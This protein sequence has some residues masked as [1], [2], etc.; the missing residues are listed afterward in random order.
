MPC[1][2]DEP[3]PQEQR[4]AYEQAFLHNST[5]ADIF[6]K[7]MQK[8]DELPAIATVNDLRQELPT[9]ALSWWKEHKLRDQ[10]RLNAELSTARRKNERQ[11]AIDKLTPY[12]RKLLGLDK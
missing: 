6:C 1:R 8:I 12:E 2:T 11:A 4:A 3:T 7:T 5:L 10:H 9:A